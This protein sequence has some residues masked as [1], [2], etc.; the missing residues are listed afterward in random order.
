M[1]FCEVWFSLG[2]GHQM[3]TFEWRVFNKNVHDIGY[4][5]LVHKRLF[6]AGG[7]VKY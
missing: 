2:N 3:M 7:E 1:L 5:Q 6:I 4:L